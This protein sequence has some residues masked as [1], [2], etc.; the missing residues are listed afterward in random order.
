MPRHGP[1]EPHRL[2]LR[3]RARLPGRGRPPASQQRQVPGFRVP[4]SEVPSLNSEVQ[5]FNVSSSKRPSPRP[6]NQVPGSRFKTPSNALRASSAGGRWAVGFQGSMR[7][8][9]GSAGQSFPVSGFRGY[10]SG[11]RKRARDRRTNPRLTL[12]ARRSWKLSA[13][14][15]GS[16]LRASKITPLRI[17]MRSP[18]SA[19]TAASR[20]SCQQSH[21][22]RGFPCSGPVPRGGGRGGKELPQANFP[23]NFPASGRRSALFLARVALRRLPAN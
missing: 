2:G 20:P 16:F 7:L 8:P 4:R 1:P 22:R 17:R 14:T 5:R 23:P 6:K 18:N 19:G 12:R 3:P 9:S 10:G 15:K 13:E 21:G 11:T